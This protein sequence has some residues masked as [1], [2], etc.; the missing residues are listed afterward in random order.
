M[1]PDVGVPTGTGALQPRIAARGDGEV[2]IGE[3]HLRRSGAH[4]GK[5]DR[6]L[7][8]IA[9]LQMR[10]AVIGICRGG[11]MV[12]VDSQP[13]VVLRVVVTAVRVR[14]QRRREARRRDQRGKEEQRQQTAHRV[15]VWEA[16]AQV[17]EPR[18]R[19]QRLKS[20]SLPG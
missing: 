4:E 7:P 20:G 9:A 3:V 8:R 11:G 5:R 12:L 10:L 16:S 19:F 2:R 18:I 13:V 15:S 14:M 6:M 17:K 1:D